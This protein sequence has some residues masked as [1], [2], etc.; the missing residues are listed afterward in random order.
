MEI[1]TMKH[2]IM[3]L[4]MMA[5]ISMP[6]TSLAEYKLNGGTVYNDDKPF[7]QVKFLKI[8]GLDTEETYTGIAVYYFDTKE[9]IWICPRDGWR[10]KDAK[11]GII[12]TDIEEIDRLYNSDKDN[13]YL[14]R[15]HK[16]LSKYEFITGSC[17][18]YKLANLIISVKQP[19]MF[20][21]STIE[22]DIVNKKYR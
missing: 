13:Y 17:F 18:N 15:S 8:K 7:A 9:Q 14:L 4:L 12:Y 19:G 16:R 11:S 6:N 1:N 2:L 5:I 3:R 20:W 10:L 21:N 22:F